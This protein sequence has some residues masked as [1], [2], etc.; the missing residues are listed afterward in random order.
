MLSHQSTPGA[1]ERFCLAAA[2]FN[3]AC[4]ASADSV[5]SRNQPLLRRCH[6]SM[7]EKRM[8]FPE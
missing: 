4:E 1:S 2:L 7:S 3:K 5:H 6:Y 8:L